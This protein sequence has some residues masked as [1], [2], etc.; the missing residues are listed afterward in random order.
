MAL[1]GVVGMINITFWQVIVSKKL[2]VPDSLFVKGKGK[3]HL[4]TSGKV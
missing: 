4:L 3:M 1:V 2:L